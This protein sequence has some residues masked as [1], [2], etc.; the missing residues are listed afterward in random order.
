MAYKFNV[1]APNETEFHRMLIGSST[2]PI[3]IP[4]E[5]RDPA[6]KFLWEINAP[7]HLRALFLVCTNVQ[8]I[9]LS[10]EQTWKVSLAG[11]SDVDTAAGQP[12]LGDWRRMVGCF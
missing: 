11:I 9:L 5:V 8:Q 6:R 1:E 10:A 3:T 7:S 2:S 4:P 12:P